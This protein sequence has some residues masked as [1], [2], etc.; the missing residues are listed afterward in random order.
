MALGRSFSCLGTQFTFLC[1]KAPV[2]RWHILTDL[3]SPALL[4]TDSFLVVPTL[5]EKVIRNFLYTQMNPMLQNLLSYFHVI[6]ALCPAH[7]WPLGNAVTQRKSN[8]RWV[9][10]TCL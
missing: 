8:G 2:R 1:H 3:W 4:M 5:Q 10:L 6:R 7:S 9:R